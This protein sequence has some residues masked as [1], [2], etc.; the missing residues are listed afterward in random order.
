MHDEIASWEASRK[1]LHNLRELR[2]GVCVRYM[3][4]Q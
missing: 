2:Y 4:I 3:G 1:P